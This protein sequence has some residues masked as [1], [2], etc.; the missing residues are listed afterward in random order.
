[1]GAMNGTRYPDR[2]EIARR[3]WVAEDRI[4]SG[5]SK[6]VELPES[7][8]VA[9][10]LDFRLS[11]MRAASSRRARAGFYNALAGFLDELVETGGYT[12]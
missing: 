4:I 9:G 8:P 5:C 3:D 12:P 7:K 2:F 10:R 11:Q 6:I 1:M